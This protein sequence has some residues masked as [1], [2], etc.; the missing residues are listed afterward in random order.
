MYTNLLNQITYRVRKFVQHYNTLVT[1]CKIGSVSIKYD[2]NHERID[3]RVYV[4]THTHTYL[5]NMCTCSENL[6]IEVQN[7]KTSFNALKHLVYLRR[8]Y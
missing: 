5:E 1:R 6:P 8:V 3:L 2:W 4:C 7:K